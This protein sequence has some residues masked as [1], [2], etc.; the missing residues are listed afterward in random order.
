MAPDQVAP[1]QTPP[2]HV[3]P[4]HVAPLQVAPFQVPPDQVAPFQVPP[5]HVAPDGVVMPL[6]PLAGIAGGW[7]CVVE[8]LLRSL[9]DRIASFGLILPLPS[10]C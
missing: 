3:A 6:E 8:V 1:D 2:D 10:M 5:D 7:F 9:Y 4:D